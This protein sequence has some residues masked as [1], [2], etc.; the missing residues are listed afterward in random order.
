METMTGNCPLPEVY[1]GGWRL[2]DDP[3]VGAHVAAQLSLHFGVINPGV[4]S[5]IKQEKCFG[6][7]CLDVDINGY[8]L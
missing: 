8:S 5:I 3:P 1:R 4:S 6:G 7:I 2:S